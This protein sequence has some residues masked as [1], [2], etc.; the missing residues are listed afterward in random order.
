MNNKI[1]HVSCGGLGHGGVSAV[2]FSIV[3]ALHDRFDFDCVVFKKH[4]ERE[5]LFEK[6]G[7]LFRINAYNDDGKRHLFE[8]LVRPFRMYFGIYRICRNNGYHAIHCHNNTDEGICLL[9]AKH[10]GVP[11]RIAHSHNTMSPKKKSFI[12]KISECLNRKLIAR[13]ATERVGCSKAACAGFFGEAESKVIFNA[14]DLSRFSLSNRVPHDRLTFIH[15]GRYTYLKNQEMVLDIFQKI[16]RAVPDCRLLMVGFGEDK[17][18]LEQKMHTLHLEDA[19]E[20]IPG[21]KVKVEEMYAVS[22]YMI[23]PSKIEGFGI[24]L[25]EAQAMGI[26]CIDSEAVQK[27]ADAGL[28]TYIRLDEGADVWA[29]KIL[30]YIKENKKV[31]E[32]ALKE[33]LMQYSS[34]TIG[35]QYALVYKG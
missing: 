23:F 6:Y 15:V 7:R 1:L 16:H 29:D 26:P 2:I 21:D 20:M 3:E 30:G 22:D 11:I 33:R 32:T 10:A 25:I 31:D 28:L 8:L 9:A 34:E 18:K 27:E 19:V 5:P 17:E 14:V 35:E 24:V 13:A 4:C 12:L